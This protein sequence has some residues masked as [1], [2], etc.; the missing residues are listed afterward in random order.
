MSLRGKWGLPKRPEVAIAARRVSKSW[1]GV[2][3]RRKRGA[4]FLPG[5]LFP[6]VW[7]LQAAGAVRGTSRFRFPPSEQPPGVRVHEQ[8]TVWMPAQQ[9]RG[10][11]GGDFAGDGAVDDFGFL[12]AV[13]Q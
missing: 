2:L 1:P 10:D 8:P 11:I 6:C 12:R 3:R 4:Q 13:G 7:V 5:A 9:R